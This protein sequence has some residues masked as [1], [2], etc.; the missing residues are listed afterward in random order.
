MLIKYFL[1]LWFVW[2]L[3]QVLAINSININSYKKIKLRKSSALFFIFYFLALESDSL[4]LRG[5]T[6]VNVLKILIK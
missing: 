3:E 4:Y 2:N 5:V 6:L 1:V